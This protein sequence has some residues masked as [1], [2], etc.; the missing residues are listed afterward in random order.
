[1]GLILKTFNHVGNDV[2]D[3]YINL[4]N[5]IMSNELEEQ[6]ISSDDGSDDIVITHVKVWK[7]VAIFFV[8]ISQDAYKASIE[9]IQ[10]YKVEFSLDDFYDGNV[11]NIGKLYEQLILENFDEI[12]IIHV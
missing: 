3:V 8:Y 5:V 2:E 6:E 11:I 12:E 4:K 9:P 1:M 7:R 10:S